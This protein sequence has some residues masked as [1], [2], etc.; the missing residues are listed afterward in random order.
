MT[1]KAID[2]D[3]ISD[4]NWLSKEEWDR[5]EREEKEANQRSEEEYE[6]QNAEHHQFLLSILTQRQREAIL[7]LGKGYTQAEVAKTLGI[8][9]G[10][11]SQRWANAKRR[12]REYI[13]KTDAE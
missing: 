8:T 3:W 9:Q 1:Q 2:P 7:L 12:I 6:R 5:L 11:V 10:A 13:K 4:P